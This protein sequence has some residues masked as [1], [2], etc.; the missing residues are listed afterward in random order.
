LD[1]VSAR[2]RRQRGLEQEILGYPDLARLGRRLARAVSASS[3]DEACTPFNSFWVFY[4]ATTDVS[5]TGEA[6]AL[7]EAVFAKETP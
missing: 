5:F 3:T 2:Y 7:A 6:S 1:S 4:A